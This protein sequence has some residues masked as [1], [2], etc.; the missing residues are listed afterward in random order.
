[1]QNNVETEVVAAGSVAANGTVVFARGGTLARSGAGIYT[2]TLDK[3]LAAAESAILVTS[4]TT[5]DVAFSVTH[6]SNLVKTING[7]KIG[8]AGDHAATD[9]PFDVLCYRVSGGAGR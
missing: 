1:M 3:E 7:T 4:R 9:C 8:A 6:T 5:P 2:I